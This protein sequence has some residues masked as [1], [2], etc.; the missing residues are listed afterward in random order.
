MIGMKFESGVKRSHIGV[1]FLVSWTGIMLAAFFPASQAYLFTE[2]LDVPAS[3]HGKLGGN[4]AFVGEIMFLVVAGFC[5]ALSDKIGRRHIMAAGFALMAIGLF[6]Y[7]RAESIGALYPGRFIFS[8]GAAAYSVMIVAIIADYAMDDSRGKLTGWMGIFN[9]L[10][11]MAA[12][13]FFTRLPKI[14]QGRGMEPVEAGQVMYMAVFVI[15]LIVSVIAWFGLKKK[16]GDIDEER[17]SVLQTLSDG[18]RAG[19]NPRILLA[20][21]AG[22][23]SRGNLTIVGTFFILWLS[24][25]G[26]EVGMDRAGAFAR[27][28]MIVGIAQFFALLGAPVFGILSDRIDRVTALMISLVFSFAGYGGTFFVSDPFSWQMI[29]CAALIGVG[30]VAVIITSA[31]L[32]AEEA[33]KRIRGAVIGFFTF[34]GA[35]GI[36]AAAKIGGHL[37]DS[38]SPAGPFI[39]FGGLAAIVCVW[40][41]VLR[42]RD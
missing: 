38:W 18:F 31:V 10:G 27:G 22:F 8:A 30:E 11:A 28:G 3:D 20:Y 23:I 41:L 2:F 1:F 14:M 25:Y 5:G 39:L 29:A 17:T 36:M 4:L 7:S 9:G 6:V 15:A 16:D 33:P 12:V 24:N 26:S 21:A 37:F 42:T 35:L 13:L 34:C 19:K 32:I 40:A